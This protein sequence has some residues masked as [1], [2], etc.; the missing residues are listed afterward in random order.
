MIPHVPKI[1]SSAWRKWATIHPEPTVAVNGQKGLK[2]RIQQ[3]IDCH[4]R[5]LHLC[6]V[7][8]E[9]CTMP[10]SPAISAFI[11]VDEYIE[12]EL[13]SEIRHEYVDGQVYAMG[14][15][16]DSHGLIVNA[17]AFAL[18]PAARQKRCQLFPRT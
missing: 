2:T 12:G 14:K 6:H 17:R 16:S 9:N 3:S 4:R 10:L 8:H 7:C 15:A 1:V 5:L 11:S 18:T 13:H